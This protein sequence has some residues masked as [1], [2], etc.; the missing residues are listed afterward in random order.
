MTQETQAIRRVK[1]SLIVLIIGIGSLSS[2]ADS[3]TYD[4][5]FSFEG[6]LWDQ[7]VNP[8]FVVRISDTITPYQLDFTVR[9]TTDYTFSNIWMNLSIVFPDG[10]KLRRPYEL[11]ITDQNG[12]LGE[13]SGTVVSNQLSFPNTK[14]PQKGRYTFILEQATPETS[15]KEVLDVGLRVSSGNEE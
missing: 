6:H 4:R 11:K 12:W 5:S 9:T 2:C 10:T 13:K 7:N 14:L 3:A 8:K 1:N 15:L